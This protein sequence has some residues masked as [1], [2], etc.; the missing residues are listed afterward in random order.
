MSRMAIL[1]LLHIS[2]SSLVCDSNR[3]THL[4]PFA[5]AWKLATLSNIHQSVHLGKALG[6]TSV[7]VYMEEALIGKDFINSG[8]FLIL[9]FPVNS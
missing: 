9:A 7:F 6:L 3:F 8:I 4:T 1:S 2:Q 5:A